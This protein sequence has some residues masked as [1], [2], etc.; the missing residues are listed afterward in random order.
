MLG[1][2]SEIPLLISLTPQLRLREGRLR[3]P[4]G[5]SSFEAQ[6][7]FTAYEV[8]SQSLLLCAEL[9]QRMEKL[10]LFSACL[11]G[12]TAVCHGTIV[13]WKHSAKHP[14]VST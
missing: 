12:V 4:L 3:R 2:G 1:W 6:E 7:V 5:G 10:C 9:R 8:R 14:E 11:G 13:L